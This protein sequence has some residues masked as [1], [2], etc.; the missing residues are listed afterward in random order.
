MWAGG[1]WEPEYDFAVHEFFANSKADL[2]NLLDDLNFYKQTNM[3]LL[4]V[5]NKQ[6]ED[7]ELLRIQIEELRNSLMDDLR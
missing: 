4:E 5:Q 2:K 7:I 3:K 6:S 1:D